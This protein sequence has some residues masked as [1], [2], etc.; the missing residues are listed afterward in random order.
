LEGKVA[1]GTHIVATI[2]PLEEGEESMSLMIRERRG[3]NVNKEAMKYA[4]A[5]LRILRYTVDKENCPK[6]R[7][8]NHERLTGVGGRYVDAT[9]E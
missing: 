1:G 8:E 3:E 4:I 6:G 9:E 2:C 7:E 5:H